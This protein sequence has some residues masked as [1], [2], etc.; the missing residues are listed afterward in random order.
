[1]PRKK[2]SGQTG[3][4]KEEKCQKD[5]KVLFRKIRAERGAVTTDSFGEDLFKN[6]GSPATELAAGGE[7]KS[8]HYGHDQGIFGICGSS[9]RSPHENSASEFH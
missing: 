4:K 1:V 3:P 8:W 2:I 7:G 6:T 9:F 5:E